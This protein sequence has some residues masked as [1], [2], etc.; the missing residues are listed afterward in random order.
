MPRYETEKRIT[1]GKTSYQTLVKSGLTAFAVAFVVAFVVASMSGCKNPNRAGRYR[2]PASTSAVSTQPASSVAATS[3]NTNRRRAASASAAAATQAGTNRRRAASQASSTS[4]D[5]VQLIDEETAKDMRLQSAWQQRTPAISSG[6]IEQ[7]VVAGEDIVVIGQNNVMTVFNAS[8]GKEAW[9]EAPVPP[10]EKIFGIDRFD[11]DQEDL[12]LVTT[13]T[14][15]YI[16]GAD[17]GLTV[18]RQNLAQ[19]PATSVLKV[20]SD[21]IYGTARGRVVWHNIPV[22]YELKANGLESQIAGAPAQL[23]GQTSAVSVNGKVGLFDSTTARRIWTRQINAGFNYGPV[24]TDRAIYAS[25]TGQRV[26]CFDINTGQTLWNYFSEY[27]FT[28]APQVLDDRIVQEV[29]E[30]GTICLETIPT[31]GSRNGKLLWHNPDLKGKV[32]T[33]LDDGLVVWV[34]SVRTLN[35]VDPKNGSIK[36]AFE[37]PSVEHVQVARDEK[38][39]RKMLLVF[40]SDGRVQK[41]DPRN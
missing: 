7:V 23:N 5:R 10:R 6:R 4:S 1:G 34:P 15:L 12:L 31:A 17:T 35:I 11:L 28:A 33:V 16:V 25:D 36:K 41:L 3:A 24:M 8:S 29:G 40:N 27:P 13:D 26:M 9:H 14:D 32:V 19:I 38:T 30:G 2:A 20:G 18:T 37:L 21:L 39:G 22:G